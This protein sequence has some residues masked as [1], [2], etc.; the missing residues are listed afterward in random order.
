MLTGTEEICP[1]WT[2]SPLR[3]FAVGEAVVSLGLRVDLGI[4]GLAEVEPRR[5]ELLHVS[6]RFMEDFRLLIL[7]GEVCVASVP[8][9]YRH[10]ADIALELGDDLVVDLS[11]VTFI[12]ASGLSFLIAAHK[13]LISSGARLIVYSPSRQVRFLLDLT[14][15]ASYLMIVPDGSDQTEVPCERPDASERDQCVDWAKVTEPRLS[16]SG[17]LAP[18]E[19]DKV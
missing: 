10:L 13:Q 16:E 5:D 8:L 6:V 19:D 17:Y 12:D 7:T 4:L 14:R 18:I 1:G 11:P 9:L 2:Y 15:L 3:S